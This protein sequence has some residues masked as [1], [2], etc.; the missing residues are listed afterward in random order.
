MSTTEQ[1]DTSTVQRRRRHTDGYRRE[2]VAE[3]W[4]GDASVSEVAR[5]HDLN[6]NLVFNWRRRYREEFE[7]NGN[8]LIPIRLAAPAEAES[9]VDGYSTTG[10]RIGTDGS[11]C[12]ELALAS[13]HRLTLSGA[14]DPELARIVLGALR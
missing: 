12:I 5:R 2:V 9:A 13:G 14:V 3:T 11:A 10:C 1:V 6:A 8:E 4:R 7:G